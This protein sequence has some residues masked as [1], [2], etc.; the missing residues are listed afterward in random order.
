MTSAFNVAEY[1]R[2]ETID[3][4]VAAVADY[5]GRGRI[6]AGGTNLLVDRPSGVEALIDITRLDLGYIRSDGGLAIGALATVADLRASPLLTGPYAILKEAAKS[7]GHALISHLATIGGNI[8]KAHPV[9]DFPPP[10][11]ALDA[12]VTLTG[13]GGE[14]AMA[15]EE[16]FLG[17]EETA[18]GA[19]EI[20]TAINIPAPPPRT[21]AAFLKMGWTH[22]DMALV[23]AAI[24]VTL[25]PDDK[26]QEAR[27]ALGTAAPL[28][29]RAKQAEAV[30]QGKKIDD[31][32]IKEAAAAAERQA[33]PMDYH[34]GSEAY[35]RHIIGVFVER[36]LAEASRKAEE[37]A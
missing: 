17:F 33:S 26:C 28:P 35:K 22:V 20:V 4:A 31:A 11:L 34:R 37:G 27:I 14:R 12:E 5:G 23:N 15:L 18:L 25:G 16:F 3:E 30:L 2:P 29:F 21:G 7:H 19:G 32:L 8:C 9:L 13:G 1:V 24:L 10:L 36:G 6:I